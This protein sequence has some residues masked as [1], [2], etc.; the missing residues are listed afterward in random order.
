V[1]TTD[2]ARWEQ[3]FAAMIL[4]GNRDEIAA[5]TAGALA[6]LDRGADDATAK[7]AGRDA[8]RRFRAARSDAPEDDPP[9]DGATSGGAIDRRPLLQRL[10]R[11]RRG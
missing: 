5:A 10:R 2:R 4:T 3:H 7:Q 11:S 1:A 8:L 9:P 6:A